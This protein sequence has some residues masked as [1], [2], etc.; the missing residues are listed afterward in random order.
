MF[1]L[2]FEAVIR[3]IKPSAFAHNHLCAMVILLLTT[4]VQMVM[5]IVLTS[6]LES[7]IWQRNI[8]FDRGKKR[9][10]HKFLCTNA[11]Y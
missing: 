1:L 7:D 3:S 5:L 9:R 6:I 2:H 10:G 11:N 8:S 4:N